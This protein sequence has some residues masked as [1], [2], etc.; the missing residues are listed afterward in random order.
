MEVL[1][2][3]CG[4]MGGA[5]ARG[6][7]GAHR[8]RVFDPMAADL[9][10]GAERLDALADVEASGELAVVLAVKPQVFPSIAESLRPLAVRDALL[11]SIMA[12]I[13]LQGLDD[14]LGSART[15][16]TMP[17]TPAAIG[18]GITAAVAGREVRMGDFAAVNALLAPTG[19][20]VWLDDEAQIDAV[21]AVSGSGPAYFFRFTEA[22]AKAGADEGLPAALAMQ[23]ARATFTG[24]AALAAADPAEL[25]E[26]RRQVT[27]PGGTTAAGLAQ[28]DQDDAIDRLARAVVEAAAARSRELAG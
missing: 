12:G 28:L 19:Q 26:L 24:A 6:W 25:A 16:R 7:Q 22:L 13:T 27:S 18:Q 10:E 5:M 21:T 23:L 8:V 2:V 14:A 1:L 4:R 3:G 20:V 15:V 11:V 17:N 9:P